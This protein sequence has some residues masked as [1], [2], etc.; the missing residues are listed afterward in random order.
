MSSVL[1]TKWVKTRKPHRCFGCEREFPA[2]SEMRFDV[3]IDD[4]LFNCYL[5]ETCTEVMQELGNTI[6]FEF[7]YGDLRED[8]L[9]MERRRKAEDD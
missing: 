6:G 2:G 3:C 4:G 5:C 8:T 1:S 7:C 9:E